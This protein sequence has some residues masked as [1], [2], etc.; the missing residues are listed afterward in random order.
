MKAAHS[1]KT[2]AE[3]LNAAIKLSLAEDHEGPTAY[4]E[5]INEPNLDFESVVNELQASGKI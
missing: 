2:I 3:L 1:A 4:V 5:R